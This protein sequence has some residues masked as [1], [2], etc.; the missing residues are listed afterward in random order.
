MATE[1]DPLTKVYE[2]LWEQLEA[3]SDFTRLVPASHR[4]KYTGTIGRFPRADARKSQERPLVSIE[5]ASAVSDMFCSS[6]ASRFRE[7]FK[8]LLLTED[9][10][11]CYAESSHYHG[12]NPLR[13]CILQAMMGWEDRLRALSWNSRSGFVTHCY[14]EQAELEM[15]GPRV[16]DQQQ[17]YKRDGWNAVWIGHVEMYFPS[18]G[19]GGLTE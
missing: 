13:W 4:V 2:A 6:D 10:R 7:T 9:Q 19:D 17:P 1:K 8:I 15:G 18:S 14:V 5:P 16:K 3:N 12:L 11:L